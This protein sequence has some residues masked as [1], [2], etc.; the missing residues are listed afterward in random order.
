MPPCARLTS[1]PRHM[2][3]GRERSGAGTLGWRRG[4][5]SQENSIGF[6]P[7]GAAPQSCGVEAGSG[8]TSNL[9]KPLRLR[10]L[11]V[12]AIGRAITS[13]IGEEVGPCIPQRER[14]SLPLPLVA[15]LSIVR[16]HITS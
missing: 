10:A 7:S 9:P 3:H 5:I 4:Y 13:I 1:K 2:G 8:S 14:F 12:G 16:A 6:A 11:C 15:D